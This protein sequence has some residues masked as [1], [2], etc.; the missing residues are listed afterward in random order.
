MPGGRLR[1]DGATRA[2]RRCPDKRPLMRAAA[3]VSAESTPRAPKTATKKEAT[4]KATDVAANATSRRQA[5]PWASSPEAA[6]EA[7]LR[8][9]APPMTTSQSRITVWPDSASLRM[10]CKHS[11]VPAMK[12]D[13]MSEL[14][15]EPPAAAPG[16]Y[17]NRGPHRATI[18]TGT[19]A[20][21]DDMDTA[22]PGCAPHS[23]PGEMGAADGRSW[24]QGGACL[25][26]THAMQPR[27]IK[28]ERIVTVGTRAVDWRSVGGEW[29]VLGMPGCLV[30]CML[31][32]HGCS[33]LSVPP[34]L[35]AMTQQSI[36]KHAPQQ[37]SADL[38]GDSSCNHDC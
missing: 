34:A 31:G 27:H 1:G 24:E 17:T 8:V 22:K 21:D 11:T 4:V 36:H 35:F 38:E 37:P 30:S 16:S 3:E 28:K 15:T 6:S 26:Q 12:R 33:R 32:C 9:V 18:V 10:R 14:V 23:S 19:A 25:R 29:V 7:A 5:V 13:L 2:W 20:G